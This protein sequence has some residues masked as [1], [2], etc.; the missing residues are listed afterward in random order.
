MSIGNWINQS[1]IL[2]DSEQVEECQDLC[3]LGS[4]VTSDVDCD[5]DIEVR[6]SK[7]NAAFARHGNIWASKILS[8]E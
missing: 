6:L 4:T 7:A 3:Y 2:V 5:N 8:T 1:S